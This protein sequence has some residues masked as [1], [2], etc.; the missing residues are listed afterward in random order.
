VTTTQRY[1]RR[2]KRV[3]AAAAERLRVPYEGKE[4]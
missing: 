4:V 3:L 2:P 1:D